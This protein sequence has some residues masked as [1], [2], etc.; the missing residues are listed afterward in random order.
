MSY[1]K[2]AGDSDVFVLT[3]VLLTIT[4]TMLDAIK[5]YQDQI[6]A[7]PEPRPDHASSWDE[8]SLDD[9]AVGEP[10]SHGQVIDL[11]RSLIERATGTTSD[12][13]HR[14]RLYNC[15]VEKFHLDHLLRGSS[16]YVSPAKPKPE[17]VS[18]GLSLIIL[19]PVL[20]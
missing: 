11:S 3:M 17:Q 2:A 15:D 19:R 9:A 6:I 4:P 8:S 10:I 16:V 1:T 13:N 12:E 18:R 14:R 5:Q 20:S 7:R